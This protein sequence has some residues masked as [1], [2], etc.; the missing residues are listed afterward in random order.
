MR[1]NKKNLVH[2]LQ[3]LSTYIDKNFSDQYDKIAIVDLIDSLEE[4]LERI[5]AENNDI[6]GTEGFRRTIFGQ[7]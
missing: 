4:Q 1:R 6:F 7:D 2:I 5:E 3:N